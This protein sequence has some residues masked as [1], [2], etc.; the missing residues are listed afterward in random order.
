MDDTLD[1][2]VSD[3]FASKIWAHENN[4]K[5][6]LTFYDIEV[7]LREVYLV[8]ARDGINSALMNKIQDLLGEYKTSGYINHLHDTYMMEWIKSPCK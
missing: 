1:F 2:L 3:R 8:T 6:E 7:P 5:Q 4:I